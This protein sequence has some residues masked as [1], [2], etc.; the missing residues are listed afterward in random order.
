MAN[1]CVVCDKKSQIGRQSRHHR[2]VAGK[3]WMKRAQKTVRIFKPNI[4]W[5]SVDG[6]RIRVCTK[7]LK[8][9]KKGRVERVASSKETEKTQTAATA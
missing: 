3:Q 9:I 5:A 8:L 6:V 1:R 7:C 4:Q 2:G